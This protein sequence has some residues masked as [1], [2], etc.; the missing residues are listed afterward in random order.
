[1]VDAVIVDREIN[2]GHLVIW[3]GIGAAEIDALD[4]KIP[5]IGEEKPRKKK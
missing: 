2:D 5:R 4:Q 3:K 1:V